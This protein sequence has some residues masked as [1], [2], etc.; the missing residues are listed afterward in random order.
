MDYI[1]VYYSIFTGLY[2][3]YILVYS[4]ILTGLYMNY[5]L[6]YS[7]ILTG[8]YMEYATSTWNKACCLIPYLSLYI[9]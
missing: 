6:V 8:L 2:T 5:I 9:I 7:C 1:L 4:S 3:D